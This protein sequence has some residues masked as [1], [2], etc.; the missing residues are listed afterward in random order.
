MPGNADLGFL[1]Q[2]VALVPEFAVAEAVTHLVVAIAGCR[3]GEEGPELSGVLVAEVEGL[4]VRIQEGIVGPGREPV[5]ATVLAPGVSRPALAHQTPEAFVGEDI[6][7]GLR[8][9][10][11]EPAGFAAQV[12][13]VLGAAAGEAAVAVGELQGFAPRH[14]L[15]RW[16]SGNGEAGAGR[17][18]SGG[19]RPAQRAVELRQRLADDEPGARVEKIQVFG[20]ELTRNAAPEPADPRAGGIGG[21]LVPN[22]GSFGAEEHHVDVQ[23]QVAPNAVHSDAGAPESFVLF[24]VHHREGAV[25]RQPEPRQGFALALLPAS[26]P[27][28]GLELRVSIQDGTAE[29]MR[30]GAGGRVEAATRQARRRGAFSAGEERLDGTE[31]PV[32]RAE[33]ERPFSVLGRT[34]EEGENPPLAGSQIQGAAKTQDRVED[35]ARAARERQP[36]AQHRRASERTAPAEEAAAIALVLRHFGANQGVHEP[37]VVVAGSA[38]P[39]PGQQGAVLRRVLR[40]YEELGK[41]RVGRVRP[42]CREDDFDVAG[43]LDAA[44]GAAAIRELELSHLERRR[45]GDGDVEPRDEAVV[46]ALQ[47]EAARHP[48]RLVAFGRPAHGLVTERAQLA[49]LRTAQVDGEP[50]RVFDPIPV[51]VAERVLAV[52]GTPGTGGGDGHSVDTVGKEARG[53]SVARMRIERRCS[54]HD[55]HSYFSPRSAR[56]TG[57]KGL[58]TLAANCGEDTA[59]RHLRTSPEPHARESPDGCKR[60]AADANPL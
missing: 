16:H 27:C 46:L 40:L 54:H 15:R 56:S 49:A 30:I 34:E 44:G 32:R 25:R 42:R 55:T 29:C 45:G 24:A 3:A 28:R 35:V 8:R 38:R 1:A 13:D 37:G 4:G 18:K 31:V 20:R 17:G 57:G 14:R 60:A 19:L 58:L 7:P 43:E 9:Q 6:D 21:L 5:F 36:I 39:A 23:P 33:R 22:L 11:V 41:R 48:A 52:P 10:T 53:R 50:V 59:T 2:L 51:P 26:H 12:E 47:P